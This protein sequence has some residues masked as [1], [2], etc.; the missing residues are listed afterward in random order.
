MLCVG[1]DLGLDGMGWMVIIGAIKNN[2]YFSLDMKKLIFEQRNVDTY[3]EKTGQSAIDKFLGIRDMP[4]T[5]TQTRHITTL[6]YDQLS[7]K[8]AV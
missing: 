2:D 4:E 3:V 1:W 8:I 5:P 7:H 6:E